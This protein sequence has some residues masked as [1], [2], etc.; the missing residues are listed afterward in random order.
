MG[1]LPALL[2]E[3]FAFREAGAPGPLVNFIHRRGKRKEIGKVE[4]ELLSS[5]LLEL[6]L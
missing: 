3:P 4:R 1:R 6:S 5:V 2:R